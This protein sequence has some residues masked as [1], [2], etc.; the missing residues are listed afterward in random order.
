M[1]ILKYVYIESFQ[2]ERISEIDFS[3]IFTNASAFAPF[4]CEKK[5]I[6][7][8]EFSGFPWLKSSRWEGFFSRHESRE[9]DPRSKHEKVATFTAMAALCFAEGRWGS[10]SLC[11]M[12]VAR[13]V[14]SSH[15]NLIS[16]WY[17]SDVVLMFGFLRQ[18]H[19]SYLTT[20]FFFLRLLNILLG[21]KKSQGPPAMFAWDCFAGGQETWEGR[22]TTCNFFLDFLR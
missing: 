17:F 13:V 11:F 8:H 1:H 5:R 14:S 18:I 15:L 20:I 19:F 2:G 4:G 10:Q 6:K 16:S 12:P 21:R 7:T 9:R 3:W 22:A